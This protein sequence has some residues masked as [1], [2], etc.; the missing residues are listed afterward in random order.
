M[1]TKHQA[2]SD[3]IEYKNSHNNNQHPIIR[4]AQKIIDLQIIQNG[5]SDIVQKSI[6]LDII[7]LALFY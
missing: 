5:T 4:I 6:A 1:L 3:Q 2:G 7:A